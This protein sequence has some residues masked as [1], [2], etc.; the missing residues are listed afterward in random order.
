MNVLRYANRVPLQ[1]QPAAC[2]IT[3]SVLG[4]NWRPYGLSQSRGSLPSGPVTFMIHMASVWV[5]FTSESKEAVASYPEIQK[6]LRLATSGSGPQIRHVSSPP[7]IR[8]RQ[9]GER[10]NILLRYLGEVADAVSEMKRHRSSGL[11]TINS[12]E[13]SNKRRPLKPMLNSTARG[14]PI[15][16]EL[17]LGKNV[18]IIDPNEVADQLTS[19]INHFFHSLDKHLLLR[20]SRTLWQRNG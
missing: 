5:P 13:N 1:F 11:F 7:R 4:T 19:E 3:Q 20:R 10:R 12:G 14:R 16:E 17:D 18:L 8:V 15:E 2:A 9:G 6:E